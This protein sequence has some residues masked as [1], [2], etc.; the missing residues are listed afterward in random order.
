MIGVTQIRILGSE[1]KLG[2]KTYINHARSSGRIIFDVL[3]NGYSK[4]FSDVDTDTGYVS[5]SDNTGIIIVNEELER[6]D[7]VQ[8]LFKMFPEIPVQFFPDFDLLD[9]NNDFVI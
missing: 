6:G 3:V 9:F 2:G 8:V 4:N 5:V 1:K 7:L